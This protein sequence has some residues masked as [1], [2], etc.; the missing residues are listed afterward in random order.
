MIPS[1]LIRYL[2][3]SPLVAAHAFPLYAQPAIPTPAPAAMPQLPQ[4]PSLIPSAQAA[5]PSADGAA[6]GKPAAPFVSSLGGSTLTIFF[7]PEQWEAMRQTLTSYEENVTHASH[8]QVQDNTP[9]NLIAPPQI[10]EPDSYPVFYLSS[11]VYHNASDWSVW[12]SGHK[13]TSLKNPTDIKVVNIT[14]TAVTFSWSPTYGDA[15]A[16]RHSEKL[17]APTDPVKHKLTT[18]PAFSYDVPKNMVV[19]TLRPNQSFVA[20]YMNTFEG[21]VAS[22]ALQKLDGTTPNVPLVAKP[23]EAPLSPE[24]QRATAPASSVLDKLNLRDSR[25]EIDESLEKSKNLPQ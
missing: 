4:L 7:T 21:Y 25:K 19:F 11:I 17:F 2:W 8:E 12:V 6:A 20:G 15:L 13:I 23:T 18:T 16:H 1:R 9:L 10:V 5:E 24:M 22:P 14:A 3:L